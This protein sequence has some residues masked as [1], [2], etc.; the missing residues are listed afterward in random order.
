MRRIT[1]RFNQDP[2]G[3]VAIITAFCIVICLGVSAAAATYGVA[4]GVR[5]AQQS[6]LDAAVLMGAALP[7]GTTDATR[8]KAAQDAFR[9]GLSA[10]T[11]TATTA[12]T[13]EFKVEQLGSDN[14][15]VGGNATAAVKN[16]F[17]GI[18]GGA[19]IPV[20]SAA[21]AKKAITGPICAYSLD[22]SASGALDLNGTVNV[23]M[24]CP[25][26]TNSASPSAAKAVGGGKLVAKMIGIAGGVQGEQAFS[27]KPVTGVPR[28]SD[29]FA[30]I[31]FPSEGSC[32]LLSALTSA[33]T[34]KR[35]TQNTT[36]DPGTYCGGLTVSNGAAVRLNPG[37]YIFKD[38]AF[39]IDAG[40]QVTGENILLAFTGNNA[41]L[42]MTGGA[43][44]NVTS[45]SSGSYINMQFMEN[46]TT[47]GTTT[48]S[49]GGNSTLKYDGTMYFPKSDIWIF[50]GSVVEGNSPNVIMVGKKLQF[51]DNSRITLN[52][53]NSRN[54][55]VAETP[56]MKYGAVLI[57]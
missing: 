50:G 57:E 7:I 39:K 5:T 13:A 49:I 32:T 27:P 22:E 56:K 51:Q 48:I 9:G 38:G 44:M 26:Q 8:I 12:V 40:A 55:A 23:S 45:P 1:S 17:S 52:Q 37:I 11:T 16:A 46:R 41:G 6:A 42:W 35:I 20:A 28:V 47:S 36:L 33:G 31:P 43:V 18:I 54:L 10:A 30:N 25:V 21:A 24:N 34:V 3:S 29:P 14:V 2:S 15:K 4:T 19:T 53:A